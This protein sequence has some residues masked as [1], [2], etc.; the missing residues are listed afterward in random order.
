MILALLLSLTAA[1]APDISKEQGLRVADALC[2][3]MSPRQRETLQDCIK[4][5]DA[6]EFVGRIELV[7]EGSPRLAADCPHGLRG[8]APIRREIDL[9]LEQA[10]RPADFLLLRLRRAP[11]FVWNLDLRQLPPDQDL[12]KL[13]GDAGYAMD[14]H[15]ARIIAWR[16]QEAA[17][18]ALRQRL[19]DGRCD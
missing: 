2:A 4:V 11:H 18:D 15:P 13:E 9:S 7:L 14:T 8:F 6:D 5:P 19:K 3:A 10:L 1:A 16:V 17:I 12:S